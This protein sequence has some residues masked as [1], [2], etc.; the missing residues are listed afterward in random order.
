MTRLEGYKVVIAFVAIT[1]AVAVAACGSSTGA[2]S[3]GASH[4][5]AG[6][7]ATDCMRSHGVPNLPDPRSGGGGIQIPDGSSINP[8]SPAFQA[9]LRAC[10]RFLP[11]GGPGSHRPTEQAKLQMLRL[12]ECMRRHGVSGFPDPTSSMP[13]NP[14]P[15]DYSLIENRGGVV[16][17]VPRT[18]N[19][20]SPTF[21]QAAATCAFH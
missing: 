11:G 7:T 16:L 19:P 4:I 9:A 12:S 13:A 21:R 3:G 8:Q 15:A 17:A 20:G 1:C 14:N 10:A 6:L 18:I 2:P 5:N